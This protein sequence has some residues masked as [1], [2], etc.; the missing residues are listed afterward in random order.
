LLPTKDLL[1]SGLIVGDD[2]ERGG[3]G[4]AAV[5]SGPKRGRHG[6]D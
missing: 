5:L 4:I 6:N 2:A 1:H 3:P